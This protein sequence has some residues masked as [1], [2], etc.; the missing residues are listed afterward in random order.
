MEI[1]KKET[2]NNRT[3]S[4]R[5]MMKHYSEFHEYI[6]HI[7]SD[8][9]WLDKLYMY[10]NGLSEVPRC[11]I[12]G[13]KVALA[14][15]FKGYNK[16]CSK[17]CMYTSN[18][19]IEKIML[20][21]QNRYGG[22]GF[23][24]KELMEKAQHTCKERYGV[25]NIFSDSR[26]IKDN[27]EKQRINLLKSHPDI[28]SCNN[29]IYICRCPHPQCS[30][31]E[32]KVYEIPSNNYWVRTNQQI[33]LCTKL[34]PIGYHNQTTS[35]ETI[36]HDILDK[37]RVDYECNNRTILN[38]KELDVY[39]PSHK[40]AIECNGVYWHSSEVVN[41]NKQHYNKWKECND[42]G[43]QLLTL[44]EDQIINQ[45][46]IIESIICSKLGIYKKRIG[47]RQC[48]IR[49][50]SAV[51]CKQFLECNHL[52][53]SINSKIRYGLYYNNEL[54]SIMT[55][56]MKR[57]CMGGRDEWELH[58]YCCKMGVQVIGGAKRLFMHFINTIHPTT[59]ESFS[60]NDISNG[61]LYKK[62][63]F[64]FYSN[65]ISYWYIKNMKRYHRYSF[66]K[67][68]LVAMGYDKNLSESQIMKENHYYKIFDSGQSKW[69]WK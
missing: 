31:C 59:I 69:I 29:N 68:T 23:Q 61:D 30:Q 4:E 67:H 54:Q 44:W 26:F 39:I 50:V 53:G 48:Q 46:Q 35:I 5:Y 2:L 58:R 19:R 42:L 55:F 7:F 49:E 52:Q 21:Q 47:A 32:E 36:V 9:D 18:E 65:S 66:S 60:S 1:P 12:C 8:C 33:E 45:P 22:V 13:R 37:Y 11:P 24:S 6:S 34:Y 40:L 56:G 16:Y 20:T 41:N 15:F 57:R 63:G 28:I 25:D 38:G 3:I 43:L 62:L 27:Q 10:Y 64:E 51:E 14:S 17:Q